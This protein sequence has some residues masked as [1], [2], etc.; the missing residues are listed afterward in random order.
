M[1]AQAD[2]SPTPVDI[3][4]VRGDNIDVVFDVVTEAGD[5]ADLTLYTPKAAAIGAVSGGATAFTASKSGSTVQ[6]KMTPAEVLTLDD[7]SDYDVQLANA[8]STEIRTIVAGKLRVLSQT[9][10]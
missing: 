2:F 6:I 5:D 1:V 7:E 9:T 10:T 3:T 4:V 8:G